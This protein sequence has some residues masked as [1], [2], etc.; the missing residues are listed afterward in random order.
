[1]S[2]INPADLPLFTGRV[3]T[4]ATSARALAGGPRPQTDQPAGPEPAAA[5][6]PAIVPAH[7]GEGLALSRRDLGGETEIAE[8]VTELQDVDW[9]RVAQIQ[10]LVVDRFTAASRDGATERSLTYDLHHD[11]IRGYIGQE[12]EDFSA[13]EIMSGQ[14]ALSWDTREN[15]SKAV[16]DAIFGLGRIQALLDLPLVENID[17]DGHDNVSV[18]FADGRIEY[19]PPVASSDEELIKLIQQIARTAGSR[20]KDFS[21][22][23][24]KL[25]MAL[26]DGSRFAADGWY[27]PTSISIRVHR[28]PDADL[29]KMV[30][31]GAIDDGLREFLTAA[32]RAGKSMVISGL[33]ASGKTTLIRAV[34]NELDPSVRIATIESM[35]ELGLHHDRERHPSIWAAEAIP[36]GEG[37][38]AG[39]TLTDLVEAALQKNTDRLVIGE[40][41][42]D[43]ILAMIGA[44][45][46]GQGSIST[47]HATSAKDTMSRMVTLVTSAKSNLGAEDA[48]RLVAQHVDLVVHV[49]LIDETDI[50]GRR[51]RFVD[52]VVALDVSDDESTAYEME[53][54][55][56]A[57]RD[58]RAVPTGKHPS[59]LKQLRRRGFDP[60]YLTQGHSSW[61][62]PLEV[63]VTDEEDVA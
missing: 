46:A 6:T 41:V 30:E 7:V 63:I 4:P 39:V 10:S 48:Q 16:L 35:Y 13:R 2:D 31:L 37:D 50:G 20:E 5:A 21:Q 55:W 53:H 42:G 38:L 23:S 54:L 14:E 62:K 9:G 25:R 12:V 36:A 44:M 52:E 3:Q 8:P 34:L 19:F 11:E 61:L 27:C 60:R 57:G 22:A 58:E 47:I 24:P 59:W 28:Y 18:R 40:V 26:P 49:G 29:S 45:Q 1:M 51:H 17:I 43:E 32:I 33:P 56:E 15:L